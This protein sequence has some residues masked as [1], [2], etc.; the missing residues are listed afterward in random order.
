MTKRVVYKAEC[1]QCLKTTGNNINEV[2]LVQD[3]TEVPSQGVYIG[4]TSRQFGTWVNEHMQ[5]MMKFKKESFI[6][7]HWMNEHGTA[8]I[9][10]QFKF[11][12]IDTHR[13]ALSRQL[14]EAIFIRELGNL[15]RKQEF[16]LNEL[17]RIK[18]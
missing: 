18:S 8:S 11:S 6:I 3:Y 2:K 7:D 17:I 5:N 15:N 10:P 9:P 1:E 14:Q 4:E 13:D 12:I 16:R